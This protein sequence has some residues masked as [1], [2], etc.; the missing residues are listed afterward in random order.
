MPW[1]SLVCRN[2]GCVDSFASFTLEIQLTFTGR[3]RGQGLLAELAQRVPVGSTSSF[4]ARRFNSLALSLQV[5][6]KLALMGATAARP[7]ALEAM[8]HHCDDVGELLRED[9][10]LL[11]QS[12]FAILREHHPKVAAKLDVIYALSAAW[13]ET[14]APEDFEL[15]EK[16]LSEL[17]PDELILVSVLCGS[18]TEMCWVGS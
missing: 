9:D 4:C 5:T 6:K 12:F 8:I 15:L 18:C 10:S 17:K 13:Q 7:G 14:E 3:G 11:R 16:K 1:R 2:Q